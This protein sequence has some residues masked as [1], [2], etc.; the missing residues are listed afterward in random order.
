MAAFAHYAREYDRQLFLFDTFEGFDQR[1]FVES[2]G[3][4]PIE[5]SNTSITRV[6][7]L[8]EDENVHYVQGWFP[9]LIPPDLYT[10]R[11]CFVHIDCGL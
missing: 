9:D 4:R 5:F 3:L 7:D 6:R 2:D 8:V 1:D 10:S 11:F